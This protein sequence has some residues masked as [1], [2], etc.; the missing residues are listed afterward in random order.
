MTLTPIPTST[1]L[2]EKVIT[3]AAA[4]DISCPQGP[5]GEIDCR[6]RATS[7]LLINGD[8]TAVL[9]LGDLQYEHGELE[10]FRNYYDETWGRVKEI[11]YPAVGNHDPIDSGYGTYFSRPAYYSF[12]LGAWHLI[13]LDSN[14]VD[15]VQLD[16]LRADLD[17]NANKKC[18][19]AFW[20]H[21][22]FN[23]GVHHGRDLRVIPFWQALYQAHAELILNGHEHVY[24]RFAPQNP[25]GF[26]DP[27]LG[28]RQFT[29]GTGGRNHY[30]FGIVE[31]NSQRRN[32]DT[33]GVLKLTL[34]SDGYDW[35]FVPELG[36]T[37]ADSGSENCH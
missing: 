27:I 30:D 1:P 20:H 26:I 24:E 33:Y 34:K 18:T 14:N 28:I 29:V 3:V 5:D 37:F 32:K 31:T 36:R 25:D 35:Q 2:P 22:L 12:D 11:T 7:D 10:N 4:G 16:W 6:D 21:P 13:S 8:L 17:A 15:Q 19:L 9:A 23:S